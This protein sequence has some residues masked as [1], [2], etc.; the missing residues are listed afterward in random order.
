MR[1][2]YSDLYRKTH[3][4]APEMVAWTAGSVVEEGVE[5]G[6]GTWSS[7]SHWK[8]RKLLRAQ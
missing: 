5:V 2:E 1:G 6:N 8:L 7:R 4:T 3:P